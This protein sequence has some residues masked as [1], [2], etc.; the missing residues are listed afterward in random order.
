MLRF[1]KDK[2]LLSNISIGYKH[3]YVSYFLIFFPLIPSNKYFQGIFTVFA[4]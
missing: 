4:E 1:H 3:L 2:I